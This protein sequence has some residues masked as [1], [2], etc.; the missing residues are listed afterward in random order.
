M[1]A[2]KKTEIVIPR[3]GIMGWVVAEVLTTHPELAAEI[4]TDARIRR[5]AVGPEWRTDVPEAGNLPASEYE[6]RAHAILVGVCPEEGSLDPKTFLASSDYAGLAE[7]PELLAGDPSACD[8]QF[9]TFSGMLSETVFA[10]WDLARWDAIPAAEAEAAC[11]FLARA[12]LARFRAG[13]AK[14]LDMNILQ[15]RAFARQPATPWL[16]ER[17]FA[18]ANVH[19]DQVRRAAARDWLVNYGRIIPVATPQGEI[20]V[21]VCRSVAPFL[22]DWLFEAEAPNVVLRLEEGGFFCRADKNSGVTLHRAVAAWRRAQLDREPTAQEEDQLEA[23]GRPFGTPIDF[24]A[25][26]LTAGN[27]MF[28]N[29]HLPAVSMTPD[30]IVEMLIA[31]FAT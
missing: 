9:G 10:L 19:L 25:D 12:A 3:T 4:A 18:R 23:H 5:A 8:P 26:D 20:R 21:A 7:L 16:H 1:S 6:V 14:P 30:Q 31:S 17:T 22:A 13:N 24:W 29:P 15:L 11:R 2:V 28:A 27:L